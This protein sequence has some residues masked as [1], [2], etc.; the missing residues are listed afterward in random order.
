MNSDKDYLDEDKNLPSNQSFVCLSFFVPEDK[1]IKNYGIKV[2]GCFSNYEE[3]CEHAKMLQ[4]SDKYHNVFVGDM[5][6]WLPFSP[7]PDSIENSE[8]ENM[9]LNSLM[10]GYKKNQERSKLFQEHRKSKA[11]KSNIDENILAQFKNK[12]E[13]KEKL[14]KTSDENKKKI[15]ENNLEDIDKQLKKMNEKRNK[16]EEREKELN[17]ILKK[18]DD[19]K[20]IEI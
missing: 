11:V 10:R 1:K 14:N 18:E 4:K 12:K 16:I 19:N 20:N 7:D 8:Y 15:L 3:A 17:S 9:D 6:K 13:L 5:G 2:R